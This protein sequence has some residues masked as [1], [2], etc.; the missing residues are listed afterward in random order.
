MQPLQQTLPTGLPILSSVASRWPP[1]T[2][3]QS[4]VGGSVYG[5]YLTPLNS[6]PDPASLSASAL[7]A[8]AAVL[9]QA[10]QVA[11]VLPTS[12]TLSSCSIF[13]HDSVISKS[14]INNDTSSSVDSEVSHNFSTDTS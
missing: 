11:S 8:A 10:N 2:L 3:L 4:T 1:T 7:L 12:S 5:T 14:T 6:V 13:P 9:Q